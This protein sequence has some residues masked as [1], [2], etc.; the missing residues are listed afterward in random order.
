VLSTSLASLRDDTD[1]K[2]KEIWTNAEA[3]RQEK[4][5]LYE[6]LNHASWVLYPL[7]LFV[8]ISAKI[9]GVEAASTDL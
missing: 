8:A 9:F 3:E 4:E 2:V 5:N 7:A 1:K 6:R